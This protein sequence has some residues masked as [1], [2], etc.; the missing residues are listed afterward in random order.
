[1]HDYL[2]V[3]LVGTFGPG[4]LE[5]SYWHAFAEAGCT[6]EVF[7][8]AAA[9]RRSV[10][11]GRIG[12]YWNQ[13]VPM[14]PWIRRA[15]RELAVAARNYAP[16]VFV[17]I[18]QLPIRAGLLAQV[19]AQ[20]DLRTV[21]IWPDTLL[22]LA[23]GIIQCLPLYDLIA[24]Y[25]QAS[26]ASFRRL[27]GKAEWVA[28]AA[29]P[30]MHTPAQGQPSAAFDADVGFI[31]QWRPEREAALA[32]I[33]A[34]LPHARVKIWGPDW[35]RR[36]RGKRDLLHAWQ[37]R[38]LYEQDF[39]RAVSACRINLNVIDPTNYPAANMRFFE[40]PAAGGFQVSSACPEMVNE[41]RD[42]ETVIYYHHDSELPALLHR[43]LDNPD[44]RTR[45][46]EAARRLVLARHTYVHRVR[47]I[48]SRLASRN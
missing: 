6:V 42:G 37:R 9:L 18:G 11:F 13:H 46:A 47:A 10:R 30:A 39:A 28:L 19:T 44:Q 17:V 20:R 45:I 7:D 12:A 16:D 24:T 5:R 2:R 41:F 27:G 32:R 22:N 34:E 15:N 48:L 40:L 38:S 1:M 36:C 3:L 43:L 25:S 23:P 21:L 8:F 14:D 26:V 4:A 33:L 35:G 29:D 31:G